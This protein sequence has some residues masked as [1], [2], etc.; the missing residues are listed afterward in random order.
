MTQ[1]NLDFWFFVPVRVQVQCS[2]QKAHVSPKSKSQMN[3]LNYL[4][5]TGPEVDI[6]GSKIAVHYQ[7]RR[8]DVDESVAV[9]FNFQDGRW[10]KVVEEPIARLKNAYRDCDSAHLKRDPIYL[11]MA[12]LNSVL[13]WWNN[14]LNSFD[15]QLISYEEYLLRQDVTNGDLLRPNAETNQSLHCMAAHLHRYGS[16]LRSL[17]EIMEHCRAYNKDFHEDF[18]RLRVRM[19]IDELGWILTAFDRA[20]SYLSVISA[21][22]D[23]LQR[24]IDNVLAL[25]VD[26]NKA[27]SDQLLIQNSKTMQE[28]LKATQA[29]AEQSL[30]IATQTRHLTEETTKI[31][32]ATQ[33][34]TKAS[35]QLAAQSQ[36]L[37]KE[38]MKDSGAMRTVALLTAFFLPGTS[39]AAILSM[40]FFSEDSFLKG[41]HKIWIWVIL[42]LP[43]T[44]LCFGFYFLWSRSQTRRRAHRV[45]ADDFEMT[46]GA[47][48]S[49]VNNS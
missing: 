45:E 33:Q 26:N 21:F 48:S 37:T 24:K 35:Y 7:F 28:I 9:V 16:E 14:S 5:L 3:P 41:P 8:E 22:R 46:V 49:C 34:E 23:E 42:T 15:D 13:R 20:A 12:I 19:G 2:D 10:K 30:S 27:I 17:S 11:Q 1:E 36:R 40:P 43:A 47:A 38:M 18:V 6:R 29:E 39:F 31:L 25:L 32:H 44:L 4:H